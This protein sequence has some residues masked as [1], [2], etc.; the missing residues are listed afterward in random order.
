ML[1]GTAFFCYGFF[2]IQ[3]GVLTAD[4]PRVKKQGALEPLFTSQIPPGTCHTK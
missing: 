1:L 3:L 2:A 4:G